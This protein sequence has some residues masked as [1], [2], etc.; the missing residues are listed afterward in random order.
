MDARIRS[1]NTSTF[2]STVY[3]YSLPKLKVGGA[4]WCFLMRLGP[5]VK[6]LTGPTELG[7]AAGL[8][9][10]RLVAQ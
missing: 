6:L 1:A 7:C 2:P 3:Q 5:R 9:A 4:L 8:S 10:L